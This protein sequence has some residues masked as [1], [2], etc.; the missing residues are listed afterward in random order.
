[1]KNSSTFNLYTSGQLILCLSDTKSTHSI[2]PNVTLDWSISSEVSSWDSDPS[3]FLSG[4]SSVSP[5]SPGYPEHKS[6][7]AFRKKN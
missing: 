2:Q 4:S 7:T 6:E 1:M 5:K 3:P